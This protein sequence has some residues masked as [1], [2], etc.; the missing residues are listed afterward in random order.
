MIDAVSGL[1][2]AVEVGGSYIKMGVARPHESKLIARTRIAT[3]ALADM[4]VAGIRAAAGELIQ[5]VGGRAEGPSPDLSVRVSVPTAVDPATGSL[6]P[7]LN[8]RDL[9]Q[10]TFREALVEAFGVDVVL[11]NDANAALLGEIAV[12]AGRGSDDA[13]LLII[14]TG[15]GAA[16]VVDGRLLQGNDGRAGEVGYATVYVPGGV[17]STGSDR[18]IVHDWVSSGAIRTIGRAEGDDESDADSNQSL[19]SEALLSERSVEVG[20]GKRLLSQSAF[21]VAS[22]IDTLCWV[23]SPDVI[24]IGGGV[25]S[26]N[27]LVEATS[28]RLH[29]LGRKT[30]LRVAAGGEWAGI[31]GLLTSDAYIGAPRVPGPA[32]ELEQARNATWNEGT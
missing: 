28:D 22:L 29:Q 8:I 30:S 10:F 21:V 15:V 24:I 23:T 12:G 2:L 4:V 27:A 6:S 19:D 1:T 5:N 3:P 32:P 14:G 31:Y 25:G 17:A 20:V 18:A 16:L 7:C 9:H 13:L 11:M 26:N